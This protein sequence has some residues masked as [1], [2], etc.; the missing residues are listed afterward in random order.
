MEAV[1]QTS[2]DDQRGRRIL[3]GPI[4]Q[5]LLSLDLARHVNDKALLHI[6]HA[7]GEILH[8]LDTFFVPGVGRDVNPLI[9]LGE[10]DR[11]SR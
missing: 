4:P 3:L 11:R 8:D 6:G 1:E 9:W 2:I 10:D 5:S 7:I